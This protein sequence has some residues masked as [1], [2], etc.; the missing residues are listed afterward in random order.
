MKFVRFIILLV[1]PFSA[2]SQLDDELKDELL[3]RLNAKEAANLRI[4]DH[5]FQNREFLMALP[6][7]DSL[8]KAYKDN[9]YLSY[10][11]GVCEAY[12]AMNYKDS[13]EKIKSAA[14]LKDKLPDYE[15]FLGRA[16]L[17]NEEYDNAIAQFENYLKKPL[18]E[19]LKTEVKHQITYCKNAKESTNKTALAKIT[20]IGKPVNT[21]GSEYG[22]IFPSD[23][24]F[25]VFTYRGEK[26]KGGKESMP[27]K[28]DEKNGIYFED[29]FITYKGPRGEW[30]EPMGIDAINTNGHDAAIFIS[31][32]GQRLFI[33][34]NINAGNGDI[35]ESR[36]DGNTW[37]KPEKVKGINSNAWEGS[38]CL[39]PDQKTI[40]FSSERPGGIGGR[41]IYFAQLM[42]DGSWG[43]VKN[44]GPDINTR[45]DEDAPFIHADG[46]TLFFASNGHNTI[47]GYDI[48]RSEEKNGK[49]QKPFNVGKPVNTAGDD[50]FYVVSPDGQRGYYSS[51]KS[52]GQGQQDIYIAEPGM[53]GKPTAIVLLTGKVTYNDKP[54]DADIK[55]ISK[56]Y[57]KD[58]SGLIKSNPVTGDYLINLPSGNQFGL[59]FRYKDALTIKDLSTALVDSFARLEINVELMSPDFEKTKTLQID[60]TQVK[61]DDVSKTGLST[62][63]FILK[64]GNKVVDSLTYCVQVGAYKIIENFNYGSIIGFPKVQRKLYK[65]GITRFTMGEYQTMAEANELCEKAR[66]KGL[67]D[68]FV[69]AVYKDQRIFFNDLMKSGIL[70]K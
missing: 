61:S 18:P 33:Y 50:K 68:A 45:F 52:S 67:K 25:M 27:G 19:D 43:N 39:S 13:E 35:Y 70:E 26:S 6:Y 4:A 64:F 48:F 30:S 56:V 24:R 38:V 20:N 3:A 17:E 54:V 28:K 10:L 57:K 69:I 53:F 31:Q 36:Q 63:E 55:V 12:D 46:K 60:S 49:W 51:E 11:V 42:P 21:K 34:R 40:Y 29:V 44:L 65:D 15:Y 7:Y 41:D 5:Y 66:K 59:V 62:D 9:L 58:F 32:D 23:E 14:P 2:F 22:P 16:F 1:L 47:G 8:S 37:T